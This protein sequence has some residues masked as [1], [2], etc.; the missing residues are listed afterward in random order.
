MNAPTLRP[1]GSCP[2]CVGGWKCV[3]HI[4]RDAQRDRERSETLRRV[5]AG[6]REARIM[7][8]CARHELESDEF[9]TREQKAEAYL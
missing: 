7:E 4:E 3:Y 9:L 6:I 1:D 8:I 5:C 2:A